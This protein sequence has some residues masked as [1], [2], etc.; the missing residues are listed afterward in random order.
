MEERVWHTFYDEGILASLPYIDVSLYQMFEDITRK[1]PKNTAIIFMGKRISYKEFYTYVVNLSTSLA[2]LGIGKGDRVALV[3]PN[4]PQTLISYYAVLRLGGIVVPTNPLY[5]EREMEHQFKDSG[6][7]T[8]ITLDMMYPMVKALRKRSGIRTVIVTSIADFLKFPLTL[9][10]H[11]QQVAKKQRVR[12]EDNVG[13][14]C[15]T[16]LLK[17]RV[18][19][20]A[21][22]STES[23]DVAVFQYT[24]G[25]TGVSK[26]AMLTNRNL[27]MNVMQVRSWFARAKEGKEILLGVLPL[28]HSFG[29]T[30]VMNLSIYLGAAVILIPRFEIKDLLKIIQKYNPTLFPGVP[31]M[32][33][34]INNHPE[35]KRYN[36]SSIKFC[37]SGA[38]PLPLDVLQKFEA[39]SGGKLVEG[40]GLSESSPVTHCNPLFGRRK[41]GSIGIPVP[42]TDCKIVDPDTGKR[43]LSAG[44][45]GELCVK[46]P[47]VMKGYWNMESET[48]E[49]LRDGWLYTGDLA[50]MDEDGYVYVVDRKKDIIIAGGFNIY[51]RDIEEV[52]FEHPKV[53]EVVVAGIP[54]QYRGETV[55]AFIVLRQGETATESEFVTYCKERLSPYKVPKLV[56][57]R[58]SLPKS[59]VG[60]FLRRSLVEEE[61]HKKDM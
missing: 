49:V 20:V 19:S 45:I 28:F 57:F 24:G 11:I 52:L 37:I 48:E 4:C 26:G 39:T 9:I 6:T 38:A 15:F 16:D 51:P 30:V 29:I 54:D 23:D 22:S 53:A 31:T 27:V 46:G 55:K 2:S 41:E 8:V 42:E 40:Y 13:I 58:E 21:P 14:H 35:V 10:Y 43:V 47:Q 50:K 36:L 25:T 34:G 56:E 17:E 1:Y 44:E 7:E 5:T 59:L 33:I 3:L 61:L 32:Y 60:K 12:I 18:P